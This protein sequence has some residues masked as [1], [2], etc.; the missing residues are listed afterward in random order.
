M[1]R[2]EGQQRGPN[3]NGDKNECAIM[4][5]EICQYVTFFSPGINSGFH[6]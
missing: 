5:R 3:Y 6:C 1:A 2:E 4:A